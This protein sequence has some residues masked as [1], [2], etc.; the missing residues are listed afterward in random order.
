MVQKKET[1]ELVN[2]PKGKNVIGL[3]WVYC[4]KYYTDGSV[5]MHKAWIFT[6]EYAQQEGFNFVETLSPVAHFNIVNTLSSLA[7]QL[8]WPVYKFDVNLTFLNCELEEEVYVTQPEGCIVSVQESKV[9]R[10]KK[11]LVGTKPSPMGMV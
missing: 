2:S 10:L 8:T 1:W 3:K 7:I 4:T 9:Y 5:Q 6:K 11:S